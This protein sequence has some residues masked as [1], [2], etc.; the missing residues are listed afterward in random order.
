[1]S[2]SRGSVRRRG[3]AYRVTYDVPTNNGKRRQRTET[4]RT[5][6]E[7]EKLL[8]KRLAELDTG[9][10]N[11]AGHMTFNELADRYLAARKHVVEGTTAGWYARNL[12]HHVRPGLG[13]LKLEK[14]RPMHVQA[15]LDNVRNR[16]RTKQRGGELHPTSLRNLLTAIRAIF[17]WGIRQELLVRNPARSVDMPKAK[18]HEYPEFSLDVAHAVLAA[19]EGTEFAL[20]VPFAMFTGARRGE[21]AALRWSDV[22]LSKGRFSIKQSAALLDGKTIYKAPKSDR[23]RRTEALPPSLVVLL[24]EHRRAQAVRHDRLGL[25]LP[26]PETLV[27]DRE[28][29]SGWDVNELSR[30]WSRFVRRSALPRIRFHDL[31]HGF[32]TL[33]HDAGESLHAISTALGHSSLGITSSTYLHLFDPQKQARARRFDAYLLSPVRDHS[34]TNGDLEAEKP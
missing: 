6:G 16:S 27:F 22:N 32:A 34:V 28:D 7:A 25:P 18:R 33:S 5:R 13:A 11:E 14:I 23:S 21:I 10:F 12:R 30:R 26:G 17:A 29:A 4:V 15:V 24:T 1:M 9:A 31:R 20:L 8:T 3:D 19:V 2:I